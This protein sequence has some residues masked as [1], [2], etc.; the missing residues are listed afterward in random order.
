MYSS[1]VRIIVS[2]SGPM[3]LWKLDIL[4]ICYYKLPYLCDLGSS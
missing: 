3:L 1:E 2:Y 4:Y